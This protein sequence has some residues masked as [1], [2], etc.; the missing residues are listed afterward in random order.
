MATKVREVSSSTRF[1]W[2]IEN[3]S[4]L[5]AHEGVCSEVF[6]VGASKW[7]VK[8]YPKGK[9]EVYDYL[10]LYLCPVDLK[11]SVFTEFSFAV[12]SQTNPKNTYEEGNHKFGIGAGSENGWKNFIPLSELHDPD[13]GYILN[14]TCVIAI[15]VSCTCRDTE[16]LYKMMNLKFRSCKIKDEP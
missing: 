16:E 11:K 14:D 7:R 3:F 10:S 12:T 15:E 2:K 8:M 1:I 13:E 4:K 9:G 6:S 5:N